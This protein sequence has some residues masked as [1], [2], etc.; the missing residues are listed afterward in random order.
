M[1][2]VF[3]DPTSNTQIH[4]SDQTITNTWITYPYMTFK[5]NETAGTMPFLL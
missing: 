5:N 4:V 3:F 1:N 2:E